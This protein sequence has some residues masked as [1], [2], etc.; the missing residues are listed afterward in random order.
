MFTKKGLNFNK[1]YTLASV[2]SLTKSYLYTFLQ[3]KPCLFRQALF[4]QVGAT[5]GVS[6][7]S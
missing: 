2:F 1:K 5:N 3:T 7:E 6:T 4:P